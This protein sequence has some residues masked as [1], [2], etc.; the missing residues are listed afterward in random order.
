MWVI[1]SAHSIISSVMQV[2]RFTTYHCQ[3]ARP[4]T[5]ERNE[6]LGSFLKRDNTQCD[7]NHKEVI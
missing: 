4:L 1:D 3:G 2:T 7:K 6:S 5:S